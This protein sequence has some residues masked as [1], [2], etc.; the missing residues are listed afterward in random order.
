MDTTFINNHRQQA[1]FAYLEA[2]QMAEK[3]LDLAKSSNDIEKAKGF[4]ELAE[5]HLLSFDIIKAEHEF[6][7]ALDIFYKFEDDVEGVSEYVVYILKA[8][9][10]IHECLGRRK[11]ATDEM[12]KAIILDMRTKTTG[13]PFV[14]QTP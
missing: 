6:T 7:V 10:G 3:S 12:R 4:V 1:K 8:L 5:L 2:I 11:D 9:S 13:R 14:C